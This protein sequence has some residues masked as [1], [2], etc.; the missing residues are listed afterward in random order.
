MFGTIY[1][2]ELK[3]WFKSWVFYVYAVLFFVLSFF[4]MASS[5]GVFDE[6]KA[7]T[8]S[9]LKMNSPLMVNNIIESFN[10]LLYFLFPSIIGA[11]IYRDY[12]YNVHNILYSYSFSKFDYLGGKFLSAFTVTLSI[13][14]LI[15]LGVFLATLS[16]MAN[17]DLLG[18]N[19]FWNYMQVYLYSIIPNMFLMGSIVFVLVTL[20][21]NVYI[22]FVFILVIMVFKGFVNA[23]AGEEE[24]RV[25][26]SLLD[27]SGQQAISYYTQYWTIY[28]IN[29]NSLPLEQW[30]IYNRL[31]WI[32]ISLLFLL[33][34]GIVFQFS[35]FGF[36]LSFAKK[37]KGE[38]VTK[39]NFGGLY[40]IN[41]PKVTYNFS[42]V[43]QL[44]NVFSFAKLDYVHLV[45]NNV[46]LILVGVGLLFMMSVA[47][48]LSMMYGTETYPVTRQMLEV[49]GSTFQFFILINT[50]L[51][52][53]ILVHRGILSRM[54]LLIDSTSTP[55]WV[56]FASKFIALIFMQF[57]LLMVILFA[58]VAIQAYKGYYNFE[59]GLYFKD[60]LGFQWIEFIIW[61]LM[62]IAFQSAF[63]NYIVGFFALLTMSIGWNYISKLGIE[64][65]IFYFNDL[66]TPRYSDMD[67][68]GVG[69][70]K[71]YIYA[72]YWLLFVCF[73]S[74]LTLLFWRR[75]GFA[76]VKERFAIAKDRATSIIVIPTAI[77]LVA[78][79]AL[80][81]YLYYENKV[82]NVYRSAKDI[83]LLTV[84]IEKK[85]KK[86]EQLAQPRIVDV[87]VDMDIYP[88]SRDFKAQ[89]KY[90]LKNKTTQA[91]DTLLINCRTDYKNQISIDGADLVTIDSISGYQLYKMR[92]SLK[93]GDAVN[94]HFVVENKPN[95]LIRSNSP[96][97]E[98][99]TFINNGHFPQIGYQ[100]QRELSDNNVRQKYDLP[101]RERL[102]DQTDPN[103]LANTYISSD[104]D[105]ITFE[106]TVSTSSDQIAI[107][108]GYLE[109]QWVDKDRNYFH[110]KMDQ[111]MLNFYAY[112]SAKYEVKREKWND[113]NIEIYYH[114]GHDY[115][116]D[117]MIKGVKKSLD[118][119]TEN[120]SPYQHKQVRIIEFPLT[121]GAFAQSFAN[122]IPF[123]E[124]IGFIAKVDESNNDAVDYPFSV[125]SHEVAHQWW[126]HQVIGANVKGATM[127]SESLSEYSSLKVLEQEYGKGQMRKFLKVALDSYLMSRKNESKKEFPLMY[128][129]NQ[130]YIHYNKGSVV[131]YTMSDYLGDKVFN[132]V[133]KQYIKKVAF[134][135]A[136]YT[137]AKELV[138]DIYLATPDSL[139]YMV[140]DMFE[141]ITL[142]DNYIEKAEVKQLEN[143]QYEVKFRAIVSKYRSNDE[144]EK[145]YD[146]DGPPK[147]FY[148]DSNG[149][150]KESIRLRDYVEVGVFAIDNKV[151]ESKGDAEKVLYLQKVKISAIENDFTIIVD[152][153][154]SEVG[155]DP[156]YKL[157]D[158]QTYDNRYKLK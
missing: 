15:G 24:Y 151:V 23:L 129:E 104:S 32:S 124:T 157:I 102:A 141:T 135:E 9:L 26:A 98:N 27:P 17:S 28:D 149:E 6:V 35:Q 108:P 50:F 69:V 57:T 126:A 113:V 106:T 54:N 118:Y 82:L 64:Q 128:N 137:V 134:Q 83:E 67:G 92:E 19:L 96:V 71:F 25:V 70:G 93:P 46:F 34:L 62:S 99:G 12:K 123:S 33:F 39:N 87:K 152:E 60:L 131:F 74:G 81:S 52:A 142:Y 111:K 42:F 127:L 136:P 116:I 56:F 77:F 38:R 51:G 5:I 78:F 120:F 130:Q 65:L 125:T 55:N 133:L 90:I 8:A 97:L 143:G 36:T 73:I 89:G 91:I 86:Y 40:L 20:S 122:T 112:N 140:K 22:G 150:V 115:N 3:R 44:K 121:M 21:R 103:A 31:I 109:K 94:M 76:G 16:P 148:Q 80:G 158:T 105:W 68:Y 138:D 114:K 79:L 85:Y 155:I 88:A 14:F 100:R 84:D 153:K 47:S 119:Y 154:P 29:N 95:T 117:R 132:D 53:G 4:V 7:T 156:Y 145:I 30:F 18:P 61:A 144:G 49:P 72:L 13:S 10:S 59:I 110:Y 146:E 58:G 48:V 63:R 37:E 11:S 1:S 45:K 107:A 66:P 43:Q 139:K 75:G 41:L 101:E 147:I 2:F